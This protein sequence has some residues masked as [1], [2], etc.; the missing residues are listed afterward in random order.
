MLD[1]VDELIDEGLRVAPIGHPPHYPH[2]VSALGLN[3]LP[4][5]VDSAALFQR[6][7]TRIERNWYESRQIGVPR[8]ASDE[9]WQ[10]RKFPYIAAHDK[11]KEKVIE[12]AIVL[13]FDDAWANE[14]PTLAGLLNPSSE[15]HCNI[16]LGRRVSD[17]EFE[18][19]GLKIDSD[20]PLA[21]AFEVLKYGLVYVFSRRYAAELGYATD[22]PLLRAE[23]VTL[24]VLAPST[25]YDAYDVSW[26]QSA[27]SDGLRDLNSPDLQL[28]F[29][30]EQF[31][32]DAT[33]PD[34]IMNSRAPLY[35]TV[36]KQ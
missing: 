28:D 31:H 26:L 18:F 17:S 27:I 14:I 2:K 5:T 35:S 13:A 25:Y 3:S 21:A 6:I 1:G 20:T 11:S 29:R 19:I 32:P 10:W 33:S 12:K 36:T 16:D 34:E 24:C 4:P 15:S 30:F 8:T 22:N 9:N 23:R 7:L